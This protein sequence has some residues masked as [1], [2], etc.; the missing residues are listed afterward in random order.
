MGGISHQLGEKRSFQEIAESIAW[1]AQLS[2]S[3]DRMA[4]HLRANDVDIDSEE[5]AITLGP[6]LELDTTTEVFTNSEAA[7]R[8]RRRAEQRP[9]HVVPD[10]ES[11]NAVA[12]N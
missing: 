11:G 1:N 8:L 12:S 2:S 4:S 7:N 5:G 10:L 6:W 3:F 9:P